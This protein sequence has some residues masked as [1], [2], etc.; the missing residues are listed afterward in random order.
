MK[1]SEI[2]KALLGRAKPKP[3]LAGE[4]SGIGKVYVRVASVAERSELMRLGNVKAD[5]SIA[6]E[7][8]ARFQALLITRLAVDEEG[9]RIWAN[10]DVQAVTEL[11]VDDPYWVVVA[12]AAGKALVPE[13][14]DGDKK[15]VAAAQEALKGN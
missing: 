9:E 14:H 6:V 7:D 8:S 5:G 13:G 11:A 10:D 3:R 15:A 2:R 12:E 1:A 4:V